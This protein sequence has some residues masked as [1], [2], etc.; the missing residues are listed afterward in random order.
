MLYFSILKAPSR[1]RL[2][3]AALH[4]VSK[5]AHLVNIDFFKDLL[6]VLKDIIMKAGA[7]GS[8]E[9]DEEV[10]SHIDIDERLR[11]QLH[12]I[13]TA[14][15]LLTGQGSV[16]I[17]PRQVMYSLLYYRGGVESRARRLHKSSVQDDSSSWSVSDS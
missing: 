15:E 11:L 13:V 8:I 17:W 1:T 4:G 6:G 14:Y 3:S 7:D 2:L 12:C 9:E 16:R 10:E 5:F